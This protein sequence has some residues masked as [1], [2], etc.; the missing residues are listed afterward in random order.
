[1]VLSL[2]TLGLSDDAAKIYLFLLRLGPMGTDTIILKLEVHDLDI[3]AALD[4]LM[5]IS[6]VVYEEKGWASSHYRAIEPQ[7]F[8]DAIKKERIK[9]EN[10]EKSFEPLVNQINKQLI[11]DGKVQKTRDEYKVGLKKRA[12]ESND[13]LIEIKEFANSFAERFIA[14]LTHQQITGESY[15]FNWSI[16]L[17][18]ENYEG[19]LRFFS[20]SPGIFRKT[21]KEIFKLLLRVECENLPEI[22]YYGGW[23]VEKEIKK[24][25]E[26]GKWTVEVLLD[27][28]DPRYHIVYALI[29]HHREELEQFGRLVY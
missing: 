13:K 28:E 7:S 24:L 2:R 3:N 27:E 19:E 25:P 11:V 10:L 1:M 21:K 6:L 12:K 20:R 15:F 16:L 29:D 23:Q 8:L 9:F 5:K 4:E 22:I 14:E 26:N 17:R 18:R